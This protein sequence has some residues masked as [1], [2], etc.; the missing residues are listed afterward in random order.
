MFHRQIYALF[1]KV[2]PSVDGLS[3]LF[4][5]WIIAF[6]I[7]IIIGYIIQCLYDKCIN[8]FKHVRLPFGVEL[9]LCNQ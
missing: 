9:S 7:I 2:L 8:N 1:L 6:P 5:L 4:I 3:R